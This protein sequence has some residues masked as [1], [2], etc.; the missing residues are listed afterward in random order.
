M[1]GVWC[2]RTGQVGQVTPI[3]PLTVRDDRVAVRVG[4]PAQQL[5]MQSVVPPLELTDGTAP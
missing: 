1:Q 5:Y 2:D 3:M 4:Q